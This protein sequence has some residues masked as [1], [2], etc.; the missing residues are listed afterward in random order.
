MCLTNS[1][2]QTI[3]RRSF[4]SIIGLNKVLRLGHHFRVQKPNKTSTKA[5]QST[6]AKTKIKNKKASQFRTAAATSGSELSV[7]GRNE[8]TVAGQHRNSS[9]G[10][11][12]FHPLRHSTNLNFFALD[13]FLV[14]SVATTRTLALVPQPIVAI[15]LSAAKDMVC[16]IINWPNSVAAA[17]NDVIHYLRAIPKIS[18][19]V[20][21]AAPT[22]I[23]RR[24][25]IL[26]V[27]SVMTS[28]IASFKRS[29]HR[30]VKRQKHQMAPAINFHLI[31]NFSTRPA[32]ENK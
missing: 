20:H 26:K 21:W 10:Y 13:T 23:R 3:K 32:M 2:F 24:L 18:V 7:T 30:E 15:V 5:V 17:A 6:A 1:F 27:V 22:P 25:A 8:H 11:V 29:R 12:N 9:S 14:Q 28:V 4:V 31:M 16:L 19:I